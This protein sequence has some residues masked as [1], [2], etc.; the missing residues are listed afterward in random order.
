MSNNILI[1]RDRLVTRRGALLIT[2]PSLAPRASS[3]KRGALSRG[4]VKPS[5]QLPKAVPSEAPDLR[6]APGA[7][8]RG[9][10]HSAVDE[11]RRAQLAREG[12]QEVAGRR[13]G[14]RV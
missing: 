12:E 8:V 14:E 13:E 1:S 11:A 6:H 9:A 10:Q 3:P 2:Q 7:A 5:L 4:S